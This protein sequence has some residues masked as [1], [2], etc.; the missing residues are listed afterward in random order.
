MGTLAASLNLNSWIEFLG[1]GG[2]TRELGEG[3]W[4]GGRR[5]KKRGR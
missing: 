2:W 1:G 4:E 5:G 3:R